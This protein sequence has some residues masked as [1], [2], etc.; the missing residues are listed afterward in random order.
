MHYQ[1]LWPFAG[2]RGMYVENEYSSMDMR[3]KGLFLHQEVKYLKIR[4]N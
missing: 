4:R 2:C 3:A 1:D